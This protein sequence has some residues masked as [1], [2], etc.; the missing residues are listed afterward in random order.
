MTPLSFIAIANQVAQLSKD[1]STKV[2]ALIFGPGME[3]RA[4]G[5]NGFPRGVIDSEERL[6]DRPTKYQFVVHAEAN[7][8]A[9]AAR[10]GVAIEGCSLLVTALHPC[11][12]CA[13]LLIQSGIKKVYAPLPADDERWA[14]SFEVAATMFREAGV[15]V[16]FY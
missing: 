13:K 10:S 4:Q 7:A 15:V 12:D 11:N 5:W 3:V 2:G 14:D 1:P 8:I 16:E 9:N 6:N